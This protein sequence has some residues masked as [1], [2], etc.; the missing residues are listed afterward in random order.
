L[1]EVSRNAKRIKRARQP[2]A[3]GLAT[4][5]E[6]GVLAARDDARA[7]QTYQSAA[8]LLEAADMRLHAAAARHR[9]G[10]LA[11]GSEGE[12]LIARAHTEMQILGVD[13]PARLAAV[14]APR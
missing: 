12:A 9:H 10:E 2:Y 13:V 4:L 8:E 14:I 1:R 7:P 5:L 6:A 3:V 11:G